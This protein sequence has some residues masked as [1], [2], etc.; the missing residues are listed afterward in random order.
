MYLPFQSNIFLW[1]GKK[2]VVI[3]ILD[4]VSET[5]YMFVYDQMHPSHVI[6]STVN[7][8]CYVL[9]RPHKHTIT[10][11]AIK[12]ESRNIPHITL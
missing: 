4:Q 2:T 3:L 8:A 1:G 6:Q 9:S 10:Y 11:Q 7:E 5:L 12:V